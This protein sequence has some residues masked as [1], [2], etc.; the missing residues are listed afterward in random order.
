[1]NRKLSL[2]IYT[3]KIITPSAISLN[4]LSEL[5]L[6][7]YNV[8]EFFAVPVSDDTDEFSDSYL[9]RLI[10]AFRLIFASNSYDDTAKIPDDAFNNINV[11]TVSLNAKV[12]TSGRYLSLPGS[13]VLSSIKNAFEFCFD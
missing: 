1:M 4:S 9:S 2:L 6:K 3:G 5:K 12:N 8:T 13:L 7:T 11:R 10:T